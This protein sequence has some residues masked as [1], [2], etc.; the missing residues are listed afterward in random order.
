MGN[1]NVFIMDV[2]SRKPTQLTHSEGR[3]ENPV[4]APDGVH[5]AFMSTRAG[6]KQIWTMLADGTH[7]QQLTTLGHNESPIWGK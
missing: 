7:A 6:G 1:W 5:L 3:N 2:A 4:W